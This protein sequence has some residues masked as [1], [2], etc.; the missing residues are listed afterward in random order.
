MPVTL[1]TIGPGEEALLTPILPGV[2]DNPVDPE[3]ARAFLANPD[4][5]LI[6]AREDGAIA[7]FVSATRLIH[8]DKPGGELFVQEIGVA[9]P[10]QRRGIATQLMRALFEAARAQGC[11]LAWLAVDTDNAAALAFYRSL[12]GGSA[13]RQFHID[14]DLG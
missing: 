8:P 13:E 10:C 14:F 4:N 9:P 3:T 11:K 7:G 12:G 6:V 2:F 5:H 1:H